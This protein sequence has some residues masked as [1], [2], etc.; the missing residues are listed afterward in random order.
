MSPA[1]LCEVKH[2]DRVHFAKGLCKAHYQRVREG[3]PNTG[4]IGAA[5][6]LAD[7]VFM[8]CPDSLLDLAAQAVENDAR[9]VFMLLWRAIGN[10]H[11]QGLLKE[12][13]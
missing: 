3:S 12:T 13:A 10:W 2:C 8:P 4:P 7:D 6:V 1:R 11:L 9:A 5:V